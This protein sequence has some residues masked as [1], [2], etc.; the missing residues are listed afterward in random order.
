MTSTGQ[1]GNHRRQCRIIT[2]KRKNG[3]ASIGN[4][5]TKQSTKPTRS[6]SDHN[7]LSMKFSGHAFSPKPKLIMN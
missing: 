4:G 6:A 7:R 3:S 5:V 1:I 2:A